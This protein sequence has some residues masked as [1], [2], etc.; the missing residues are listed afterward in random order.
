MTKAPSKNNS[1]ATQEVTLA[2]LHC[3]MQFIGGDRGGDKS[4]FSDCIQLYAL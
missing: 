2:E 1:E 3:V 4:E